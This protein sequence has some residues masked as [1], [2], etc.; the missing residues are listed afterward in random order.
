MSAE[1][2]ARNAPSG[3]AAGSGGIQVLT[4]S[5]VRYAQLASAK[6]AIRLEKLGLRH[7]RLGRNG[8][9]RSWAKHYGMSARSSHDAVIARIQ[10]EMDA[11]FE[12][13]QEEM[14]L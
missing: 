4:G 2:Q 1:R 10:E 11:I 5:G 8:L 3:Q 14:P 12:N 7:S 13:K 9:K 6:G